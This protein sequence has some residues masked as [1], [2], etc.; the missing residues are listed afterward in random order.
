MK[1]LVID[2]RKVMYDKNESSYM[3]TVA[4][5]VMIAVKGTGADDAALRDYLKAIKY[6]EIEK[7]AAK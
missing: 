4:N 5:K 1:Q 6:A 3:A 2:G 7:M